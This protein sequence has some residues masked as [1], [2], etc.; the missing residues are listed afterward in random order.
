MINDFV[1]IICKLLRFHRFLNHS[2][3]RAKQLYVLRML[4]ITSY[5]ISWM[6]KIFWVNN[7][8]IKL[9][10]ICFC[11]SFNT[12]F[13]SSC[14]TM[15]LTSFALRAINFFKMLY[16]TLK[17]LTITVMFSIEF[18]S[19]NCLIFFIAIKWLFMIKINDD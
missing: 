2:W 12:R 8:L 17:I 14:L 10:I 5:I 15:S 19:K 9:Y 1:F 16:L 3:M 6:S 18:L 7:D 11:W 4:M 13:C